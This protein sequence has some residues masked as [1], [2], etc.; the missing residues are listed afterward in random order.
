MIKKVGARK[1]R[2]T[3]GSCHLASIP[4]GSCLLASDV[5]AVAPIATS[6]FKCTFLV[7]LEFLRMLRT[8]SSEIQRG[9]ICE[10]NNEYLPFAKENIPLLLNYLNTPECWGKHGVLRF[11]ILRDNTLSTHTSPP[12]CNPFQP[13][14]PSSPSSPSS[15]PGSSG[16]GSSGSAEIYGLALL[17]SSTPTRTWTQYCFFQQLRNRSQRSKDP[18][19]TAIHLVTQVLIQT[20]R[21]NSGATAAQETMIIYG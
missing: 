19:A 21:D 11:C 5:S 6:V 17:E 2:R 7:S 1:P 9:Y 16:F 14:F 4:T 10:V 20:G 13:S 8:G 12:S 18:S 3:S 15:S